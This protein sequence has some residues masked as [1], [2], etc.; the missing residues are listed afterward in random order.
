MIARPRQIAGA[1]AQKA[2]R[3]KTA[4]YVVGANE[5]V[6]RALAANEIDEGLARFAETEFS[7]RARINARYARSPPRRRRIA[8]RAAFEIGALFALVIV[9]KARL[10]RRARDGGRNRAYC[11]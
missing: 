8:T 7:A 11:K 6:H 1:F 3:H 4:G 10:A 2:L 5:R 9:V